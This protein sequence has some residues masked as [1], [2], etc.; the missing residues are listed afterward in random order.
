[1]LR[2]LPLAKIWLLDRLR[3]SGE[4]LFCCVGI[5]AGEKYTVVLHAADLYWSYPGERIFSV[6]A[7]GAPALTD[8]DVIAKAGE[9][10]SG[11]AHEY[12]N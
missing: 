5:K 6:S 9:A 11:V 8:Y 2:A 10:L 12:R 7:N 4:R 3:R 1:M